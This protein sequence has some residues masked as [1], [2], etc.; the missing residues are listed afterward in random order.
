M[1]TCA[2]NEPPPIALLL[3]VQLLFWFVILSMALTAA[4]III[5]SLALGLA[6]GVSLAGLVDM[7]LV[8]GTSFLGDW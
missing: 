4:V 3:W 5:A 1:R 8:D 7:L 2:D 6:V